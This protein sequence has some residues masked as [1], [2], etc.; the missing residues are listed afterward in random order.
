MITVE[1]MMIRQCIQSLGKIASY[2]PG[3]NGK[4]AD[5]LVSFDLMAVKETMHKSILMDILNVLLIIRKES[6]IDKID[7]YIF[8]ALS[9]EILDK[10]SKKQIE[11]LL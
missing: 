10:K 6:K 9:S 11:S 3:I 7:A 1:S 5:R 2:K 8:N 4:I